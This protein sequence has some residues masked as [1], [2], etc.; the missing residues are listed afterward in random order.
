MAM[1]RRQAREQQRPELGRG[2]RGV[3]FLQPTRGWWTGNS[4]FGRQRIGDLPAVGDQEDLWDSGRLPGPPQ[5]ICLQLYRSDRQVAVQAN[6]DVHAVITYGAGGASNTFRCDWRSGSQMSLVANTI[7]IAIE[8][9]LVV[10]GIVTGTLEGIVLGGTV[11]MGPGP[12]GPVVFTPRSVQTLISG[13]SLQDAIPDF[14]TGYNLN[15]HDLLA[16]FT[17][18]PDF[19]TIQI[20]FRSANNDIIDSVLASSVLDQ[21]TSST[22]YRIP[23]AAQFVNVFNGTTSDF[24]RVQSQFV[25]SL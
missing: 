12:K 11:G 2:T 9:R 6:R 4:A 13:T 5:P 24:L 20:S 18:E 23:G 7:R 14:A 10:A 21:L 3:M 1:T 15:V 25:L 17:G 16:G 19:S 22:G 8:T